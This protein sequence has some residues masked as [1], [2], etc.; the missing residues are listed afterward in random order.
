MRILVC[1][2]AGL[3]TARGVIA[4]STDAAVLRLMQSRDELQD[5]A[6]AQVIK[7][8]TGKR[9]LPVIPRKQAR[10][11][12][13]LG[14]ALDATLVALNDPRHPIHDAG[15]VNEASR[16]IEDE[17]R[18]QVNTLR[19]WKCTVPLTAEG[20][21]QRSGYPDLRIQTDR[22]I[23]FYLDPKLYEAGSRDSS[24]RTFYYEPKTLTGKIHEDAMHLLVGIAH[25]GSTARDLRLKG[26][27]LIDLSRLKVQLKA[28][29]QA[30]N[31]DVY[32][33]EMIVAKSRP[34]R[35]R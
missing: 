32:R 17:I 23:A 12:A 4:E 25:T 3:L 33:P 15:R 1:L 9:V 2:I 5:V 21:E 29:F 27:E 18:K 24:L 14:L 13:Q 11:L 31:R 6:F 26:W 28:E 20:R 7:A 35:F 22:G 10:M 16:F 19:G 8:T 30:G 34:W